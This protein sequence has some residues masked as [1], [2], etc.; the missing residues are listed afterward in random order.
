ME[1]LALILSL[2]SLV[3]SFL[4]IIIAYNEANKAN[5]DNKKDITNAVGPTKSMGAILFKPKTPEQVRFEHKL[6]QSKDNNDIK[7]D[8]LC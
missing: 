1:K 8:D 4:A 6:K 2:V 3:I 7:L 5:N